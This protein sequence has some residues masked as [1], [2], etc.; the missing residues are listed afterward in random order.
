MYTDK[1]INNYFRNI[2]CPNPNCSLQNFEKMII[3]VTIQLGYDPRTY[4]CNLC[5]ISYAY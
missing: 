5:F 1:T 4:E 3:S 2:Y